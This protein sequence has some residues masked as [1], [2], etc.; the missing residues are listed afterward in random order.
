MTSALTVSALTAKGDVCPHA[1]V[2]C[3]Q[4]CDAVVA[5]AKLL[6]SML[7]KLLAAMAVAVGGVC[8]SRVLGIV[9][10]E[11]MCVS[12]E[13]ALLLLPPIR[14]CIREFTFGFFGGSAGGGER[15][16]VTCAPPRFGL[17]LAL[18]LALG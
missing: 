14:C 12:D 16:F 4:L 5:A 3:T 6:A 13:D 11:H 10:S 8:A 17:A 18:A 1:V 9:V 7:V 2:D 15:S